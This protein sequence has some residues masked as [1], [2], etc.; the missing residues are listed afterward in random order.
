MR[1]PQ[2]GDR[3]SNYLLDARLGA[4][5]FGE[6]W[7]ATHHVF[8]ELVAIKIPNDP[9]YVR[10][11]QREG[12]VIHGLRNP[13]IVRA[14]DLDP[15][16]DPPYLVMEYV[17]GPS[18]RQLLDKHGGKLPVE[19]AVAMLYGTL[20]ALEAAHRAGVIHRDVKPAN[21]LVSGGD[22]LEA[23]TP[24]RVKVTDFGLLR[25][26]DFGASM[27]QSGSLAGDEGRHLIG[28]L[29]YMSP[30]QRDA[31]S[32]GGGEVDGRSD[33][34][35]LGIVLH[36][37]LTGL[38]PQGSDLPGALREDTPR[39]LDRLFERCYTRRDRRFGSAAEI[40]A[41]IEHYWPAARHWVGDSGEDARVARDGMHWRCTRCRGEV[42]RRDQYCIHC[43]QQ[44][45]GFVPRC[46]SC[47]AFVSR[48]DN[49]CILCGHDLR[50]EA[51]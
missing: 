5:S 1:R 42:A 2:P 3:I 44:L 11:L 31:L 18:L 21:I 39:W 37:M 4:G 13:H 9:Q 48:D 16:G 29:A 8:K 32:R 38:L 28:T 23:M 45:A 20:S 19:P 51:G 30:E 40:K 10:Q 17:D 43:G 50:A 47:H 49:F 22:R 14:I 12:L 15:Y 27:I 25:S 26:A 33:L 6:V 35:S 34:Y 36:E 7:K 41:F 24:G 46:P